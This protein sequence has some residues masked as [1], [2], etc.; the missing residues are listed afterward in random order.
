MLSKIEIQVCHQHQHHHI[1][2]I[3]ITPK[4]IRITSRRLELTIRGLK[5]PGTSR[6][7]ELPLGIRITISG[8]PS[9]SVDYHHHQGIT[10][11]TK[12]YLLPLKV[13]NHYWG[14][15]IPNHPFIIVA[16]TQKRK[17]VRLWIVVY[18]KVSAVFLDSNFH[19]ILQMDIFL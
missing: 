3:R 15:S 17:D 19:Q 5:S 7:L 16:W 1:S 6:G 8:L 12:G 10:I 11:Y 13:N 14:L 2:E 18:I 9:S 4:G